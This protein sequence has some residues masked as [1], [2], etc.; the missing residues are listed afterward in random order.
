MKRIMPRQRRLRYAA[1]MAKEPRGTRSLLFLT[2]IAAPTALAMETM[3]R[4]TLF[5]P[6]F[7]IL[8]EE[9]QPGLTPVAWVLAIGSSVAVIVGIEAQ[10]RIVKK[11]LEK[12][13]STA[14][15]TAEFGAFL[16]ATAIPQAPA[17]LATVTF[18]LG[19]AFLPVATTMLIS[20]TGVFIQLLKVLPTRKVGPARR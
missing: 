4:L 1:G 10:R 19:A 11:A 6:E 16:F 8:R 14:R 5:P 7:E 13:S 17:V 18:T 3:L 2:F 12:D 15:T 9:L 20:T